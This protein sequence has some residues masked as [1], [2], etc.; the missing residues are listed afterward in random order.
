MKRLSFGSRVRRWQKP[1]MLNICEGLLVKSSCKGDK[2]NNKNKK[3]GKNWIHILIPT[4][5]P[6][7]G[8][9]DKR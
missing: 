3:R 1:E 5:G 2:G 8:V 9:I 7:E 4:F 6:F